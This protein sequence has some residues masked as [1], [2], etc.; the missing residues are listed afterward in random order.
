ML[1]LYYMYFAGRIKS[2]SINQNLQG[3]T[4][5]DGKRRRTVYEVCDQEF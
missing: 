1:F 4:S 5:H 3:G 2:C